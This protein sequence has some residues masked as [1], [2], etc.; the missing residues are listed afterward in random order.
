[1]GTL[2]PAERH[3]FRSDV[4]ARDSQRRQRQPQGHVTEPARET[5]VHERCDVLVLGAG[6][7]GVAA[8]VAAARGGA[9]VVLLERYNHLGGLSTGGL[10]IWIDRMTDWS[11]GHVI[12]GLAAEIM[13]RLGRS[14]QPAVAGPRRE[15]WG[16]RDSAKAD[17]WSLRTAAF[18]GVV[19]HSP[20]ID[21]EM[22]KGV[23]HQMVREAGVDL[24]LHGWMVAPIAEEGRVKG[25]VFES[26][27]GRRA[28][29]ANVVVD[30][31]GEG[32]LYAAAGAAY[33]SDIDAHDIH[34]CINTSWLFAGVDMRRWLDFRAHEP[35]AYS[36]LLARG[37]ETLGS[38][39]KPIV[40]W[41]DDVATFLGPRKSGFSALD[42]DE[43]TQVE[44]ESR[45]SMAEHLAFY[46]AHAPGFENA[47][48][49]LMAPQIGT[50]HGRRLVG[51]KSVR[52]GAWDEGAVEPDEIGI[53]PS[54][55]PKFP[56]IS[57]PYGALVPEKLDGVLAAGKHI[58]CD[59]NSHGFMREI[60][61]CWL[62]GQAAGTAAALAADSGVLPR[63]VDVKRLQALLMAQGVPLRQ[64]TN[65]VA[66]AS[67]TAL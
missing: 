23:Y 26:K 12:H 47:W 53:S 67:A 29:L 30:T 49:M 24:I 36:A 25:A 11:G 50:R 43:M 6:P 62:T 27:Q 34:H 33:A 52:R 35:Q 10:V 66:Q 58:S 4:N 8:A 20:T 2:T 22:L 40:S 42:V 63:D 31:T 21:P 17:Y 18:H 5:P 55:S 46:R 28:I 51:V 14:A 9:R 32:D 41:R 57:V 19:T 59:T 7:S 54:P 48:V 39:E 65:R 16:S 37:R 56:N 3:F 61:Q 15:D 44:W 1:M 45:K 38:F 64:V 60:P 13:D